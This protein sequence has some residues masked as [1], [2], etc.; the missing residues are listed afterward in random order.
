MDIVSL[1]PP[2]EIPILDLEKAFNTQY[3]QEFFD[4]ALTTGL[5]SQYQNLITGK[6]KQD[7]LNPFISARHLL[8][9]A[10]MQKAYGNKDP[11]IYNEDSIEKDE[12]TN[13]LLGDYFTIDQ[14]RIPVTR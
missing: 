4:D 12:A 6:Y 3:Y 13:P 1:R 5:A 9:V 8:M 2:Y 14:K 10:Y 11:F 7:I